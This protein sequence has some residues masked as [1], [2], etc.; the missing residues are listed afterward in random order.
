MGKMAYFGGRRGKGK[1]YSKREIS[2]LSCESRGDRK[3]L[4]KKLTRPPLL[5]KITGVLIGKV[6]LSVNSTIPNPGIE[7]SSLWLQS[8]YTG[9][10]NNLLH[11]LFT[12]DEN[13]K[14]TKGSRA[15]WLRPGAL[16]I[17]KHLFSNKVINRWNLLDQETVD[18]PSISAFKS[19]LVYIRNNRMSFSWTSPLTALISMPYWLHDLPGSCTK[20]K[21]QVYRHS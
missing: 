7:N 12:L 11:E 21:V 10:S 8:L 17:T 15:N 18:A 20:Y 4:F 6:N 1:A 9:L 5:H 14:G 13:S 19:R 16:N 3:F 2:L